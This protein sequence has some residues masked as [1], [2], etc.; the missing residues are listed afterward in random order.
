MDYYLSQG[1]SQEGQRT[2]DADE[3]P[4]DAAPFRPM[5]VR[6]LGPSGNITNT[7]RSTE[8]FQVEIEY[9]L[10]APVTGLRVGMYLMSTRGEYIFTSFD[11]DEP[12][13]F[14]RY[15]VRPAGRMVSRCIIPADFLE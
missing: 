12:K 9:E 15:P 4:A 14:D 5:A 3:V 1:F 7:V 10:S 11:T 6:I 8:A 2:W 13:R